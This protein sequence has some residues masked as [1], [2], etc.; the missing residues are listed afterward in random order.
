MSSSE[1]PPSE[2]TPLKSNERLPSSERANSSS[3]NNSNSSPSQQAALSAVDAC[4]DSSNSNSAVSNPNSEVPI[5]ECVESRTMDDTKR[6]LI[7]VGIDFVIL[8]CDNR[9]GAGTR[10]REKVG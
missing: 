10:A 2:V 4:G 3:S 6:I 7:R 9:Y 8:C 5:I 1:V